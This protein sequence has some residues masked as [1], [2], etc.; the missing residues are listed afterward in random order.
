MG[1]ISLPVVGSEIVDTC[2]AEYATAPPEEKESA[3]LRLGW[4]LAHSERT[5]TDAPWALQLLSKLS[6]SPNT[7]SSRQARYLT[8]VAN[9]NLGKYLD[10]RDWCRRAL[11][12]APSC[13]QSSTLLQ[14]CE[15]QL[16]EDALVGVAGIGAVL[17]GVV[18]LGATLL[19][20]ARKDDRKGKR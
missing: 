2:S 9:Y 17:A 18:L 6:S 8:A 10:A 11:A 19:G 7:D 5:Q 12:I 14:E 1:R 3:Q 15:T 4:A 16:A 13:R 20:G